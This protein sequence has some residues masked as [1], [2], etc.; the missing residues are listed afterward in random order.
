M[1]PRLNAMVAAL[2]LVACAPLALAQHKIQ[3]HWVKGHAGHTLNERADE[4]ARIGL[5][6]AKAGAIGA[7][8]H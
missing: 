6:A 8:K 7:M 1:K 5:I 3:W 2:A 4:L